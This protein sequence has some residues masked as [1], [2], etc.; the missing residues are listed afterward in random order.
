MK[1]VRGEGKSFLM[2]APDA[3]QCLTAGSLEHI[4]VTRTWI[5]KRS[6]S[7]GRRVGDKGS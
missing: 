6:E 7:S 1:S 3:L 2:R 5:R 4:T